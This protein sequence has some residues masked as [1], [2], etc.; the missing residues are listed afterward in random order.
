MNELDR[1]LDKAFTVV[2][3]RCS[4]TGLFKRAA[5][6]AG[7]F[8]GY[9][10]TSRDALAQ[11]SQCGDTWGACGGG[12]CCGQYDGCSDETGF[13]CG[14]TP[15]GCTKSTGHWCRCCNGY[16]RYDWWDCC[17]RAGDGSCCRSPAS[18]LPCSTCE[19]GCGV[20]YCACYACS[21]RII[22]GNG[23]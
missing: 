15:S 20:S 14:N 4:R 22:V 5:V 8:V 6:L 12:L 1:H 13:F 2:G 9:G 18:G 10:A 19:D 3:D 17:F 7:V 21:F 16:W 11:P 23:C